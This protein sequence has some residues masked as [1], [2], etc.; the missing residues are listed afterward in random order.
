MLRCPDL[1]HEANLIPIMHKL[2]ILEQS[3]ITQT[4]CHPHRTPTPKKFQYIYY[5]PFCWE[6][7][8]LCKTKQ[9]NVTYQFYRTFTMLCTAVSC[10]CCCC[11]FEVIYPTLRNKDEQQVKITHIFKTMTFL[12]PS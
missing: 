2:L 11:C 6:V 7:W 12:S 10:C 5:D 1:Y 8:I 9:H 3:R 4:L